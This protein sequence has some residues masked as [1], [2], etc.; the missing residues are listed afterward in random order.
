MLTELF[1]QVHSRYS[2]LPVLGPILDG[3]AE[4]LFQLGYRRALV[5]R[6]LQGAWHADAALQRRGCLSPHDITREAVS[7]CLRSMRRTI[8]TLR[9]RCAFWSATSTQRRSLLCRGRTRS[10]PC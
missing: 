8:R 10:N 5:R 3:F 9:L 1:R 7:A 6:H 4:W 2:S